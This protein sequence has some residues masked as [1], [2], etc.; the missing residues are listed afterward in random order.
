MLKRPLCSLLFMA[1]QEFIK[2]AS[3]K[4]LF[5]KKFAATLIKKVLKESK[6]FPK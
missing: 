6:E 4:I 1:C 2:I 5:Q 3:K